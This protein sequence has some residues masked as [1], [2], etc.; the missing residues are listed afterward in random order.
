MS[1]H[2]TSSGTTGYGPTA[3]WIN[4]WLQREPFATIS[5]CLFWSF[6]FIFWTPIAVVFLQIQMIVQ[7]ML[8][9]WE[10][11]AYSPKKEKFKELAVVVTGCDSGF[12]KEIAMC[13]AAEGFE[14]FAGCL[15]KESL[16]GF[17]DHARIHPVIMDVTNDKDIEMT[18]HQVQKW[19][20]DN[21]VVEK[22]Q[23]LLHALVCNAGIVLGAE[24][25]F[26]D[27]SMYQK[28]MDGA[29]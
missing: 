4:A 8:A 6:F 10:R 13:A 3:Q 24:A 20:K 2:Q 21:H 29:Y 23:R 28:V 7:V 1:F 19:I 18:V 14:V 22:K 26:T 25:D 17:V 11:N 15:Q 9:Y 12:G 5:Y 27:L 16:Q